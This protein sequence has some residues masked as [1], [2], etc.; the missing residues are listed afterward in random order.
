[1]GDLVF[2]FAGL[3]LKQQARLAAAL[4]VTRHEVLADLRAVAAA[5]AF[6]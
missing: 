4:G 6:L 2:R 3:D 1:M 5:T